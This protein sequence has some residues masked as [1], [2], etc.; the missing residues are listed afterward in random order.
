[1]L[2]MHSRMPGTATDSLS[3]RE[4]PVADTLSV[5]LP[6]CIPQNKLASANFSPGTARTHCVASSNNEK[7]Y[8]SF[9]TAKAI[10]GGLY[11]QYMSKQSVIRLGRP[12]SEFGRKRIT[13]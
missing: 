4:S 13:H 12:V 11:E 2:A 8:E 1:M 9:Q 5:F 3:I 7:V 10:I 6:V